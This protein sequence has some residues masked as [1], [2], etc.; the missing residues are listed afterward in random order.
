ML[1]WVDYGQERVC[2]GQVMI[3]L[4]VVNAGEV[5]GHGAREV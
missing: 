2:R 3:V 1:E 5:Q 4:Y